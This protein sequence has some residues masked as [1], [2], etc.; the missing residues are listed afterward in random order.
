LAKVGNLFKHQ[1]QDLQENVISVNGVHWPI[2]L[3]FS[4]DRKFLYNIMGLNVPNSK[5]FCLYSIVIVKQAIVEIWIYTGQL[6]KIQSVSVN[7]LK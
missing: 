5:Y 2:E 3:F 7:L 1:H 6:I 4:G